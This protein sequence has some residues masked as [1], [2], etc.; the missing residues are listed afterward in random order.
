MDS[1]DIRRIL[2]I[3]AIT[4]ITLYERLCN[5]EEK[6]N[7]TSLSSLIQ[8]FYQLS[9]EIDDGDIRSVSFENRSSVSKPLRRYQIPSPAGK[10][11]SWGEGAA[12]TMKMVSSKGDDVIISIFCTSSEQNENFPDQSAVDKLNTIALNLKN[13]FLEHCGEL[14]TEVRP[15]LHQSM[16]EKDV[17]KDYFQL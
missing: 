9:R 2:I 14:V 13:A 15:R 4:G 7:S 5:W 12:E 6:G 10:V 16:C 17:V 3:D 11:P 1:K 8:S